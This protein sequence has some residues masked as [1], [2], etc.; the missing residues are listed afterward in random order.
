MIERPYSKVKS[1]EFEV[2]VTF[3]ATKNQGSGVEVEIEGVGKRL[4]VKRLEFLMDHVAGR[5]TTGSGVIASAVTPD[6]T[7]VIIKAITGTL[8]KGDYCVCN[9]EVFQLVVSTGVQTNARIFTVARGQKGTVPVFLDVGDEVLRLNH[10]WQL[11]VFKDEEKRRSDAPLVLKYIMTDVQTLSAAVSVGMVM[12][13]LSGPVYNVDVDDW[14][15]VEGE[16]YGVQRYSGDTTQAAY[17]YALFLKDPLRK[18]ASAGTKVRKVVVY[19][20]PW[21]VDRDDEKLSMELQ[22]MEAVA[23]STSGKIRVWVDEVIG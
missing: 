6:S 10:G 3:D 19:D 18:K 1:K 8:G 2:D 7:S 22:L 15:E 13:P 21:C 4:L 9:N 5:K 16:I 20:L 14:V 11:M 23:S 12:L 17:D